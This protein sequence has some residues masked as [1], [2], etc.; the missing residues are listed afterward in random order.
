M[1]ITPDAPTQSIWVGA[2]GVLFIIPASLPKFC[3]RIAK[4]SR[5]LLQPMTLLSVI[6]AQQLAFEHRTICATVCVAPKKMAYLLGH[7]SFG[8]T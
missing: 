6:G 3:N 1:K 4:L 8:K 7:F 5:S 2:S